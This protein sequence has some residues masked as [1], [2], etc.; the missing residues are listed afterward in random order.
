[1]VGRVWPRH[2]HCGRPLN[3]VIRHMPGHAWFKQWEFEYDRDSTANVYSN[4]GASAAEACGCGDCLEWVNIRDAAFT[5][6]VRRFF[7]KVG[8]DPV[9]ETS[10]SGLMLRE[11]ERSSYLFLGRYHFFGR[12]L[13]GPQSHIPLPGGGYKIENLSVDPR[14]RIGLSSVLE[15]SPDV[16][17]E[18]QDAGV[19]TV[20]FE[21]GALNEAYA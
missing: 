11:G 20:T 16:P 2:G 8:V 14:L 13:V 17:R 6:E 12:L 4:M 7:V 19:I 10:M 21:Y 15:T 5:P 3:S 18:F 1:M 9:R